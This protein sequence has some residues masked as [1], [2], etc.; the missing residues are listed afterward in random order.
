MSKLTTSD[1]FTALIGLSLLAYSVFE[2][3]R[4]AAGAIMTTN[5]IF[6]LMVL[7]LINSVNMIHWRK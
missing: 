6:I 5:E 3:G 1:I 7:T 2:I 4:M